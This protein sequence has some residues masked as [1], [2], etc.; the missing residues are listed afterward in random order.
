M[1]AERKL[2]FNEDVTT[3][4]LYDGKIALSFEERFQVLFL[5]VDISKICTKRPNCI[6]RN[7][8]FVI[9]RSTLRDPSDW[10][11]TDLGSSEHRGPSARVFEVNSSEIVN[12][13]GSRGRNEDIAMKIN[14]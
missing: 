1:F 11:T 2:C 13:C 12:S 8:G 5:D 14:V 6:K 7:C 3:P 10:L 4:F 9:D